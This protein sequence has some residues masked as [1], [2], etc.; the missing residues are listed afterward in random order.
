MK[1]TRLR[2]QGFTNLHRK[3]IFRLLAISLAAYLFYMPNP[4]K[5]EQPVVLCAQI[6]GILLMCAGIVGRV[7]ATLSIGGFKDR[8]IVKTELYS[9]CRNP[10]YFASFL[11][12]LGVGLLSARLDFISLVTA[13]FLLVFYP[14]MR[15]EA[16]FLRE[17]FADFA[18]YEREVPLFFPNF[19]IWKE[20]QR[21]EISFSLV[22][23]TLLDSSLILFSIP[24]LIMLHCA[25]FAS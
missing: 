4:W 14:M 16:K 25:P 23:R 11:M 22:R 8:V 5:L 9:V 10:L 15:N 7:L 19:A 18:D 17:K 24:L 21:F 13:F 1:S 3:L 20:R 6:S 2:A 12:A